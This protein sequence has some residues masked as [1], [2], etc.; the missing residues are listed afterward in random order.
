MCDHAGYTLENR[1]FH[2]NIL[3]HM[4]RCCSMLLPLSLSNGGSEMFPVGHHLIITGITT[5]TVKSTQNGH[6]CSPV[7]FYMWDTQQ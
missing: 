7:L 5:A 1:K 6:I 3:H 4:I 2:H